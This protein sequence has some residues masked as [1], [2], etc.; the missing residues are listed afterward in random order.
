MS[1]VDTRAYSQW[2][3][4]DI[5]S[6][7]KQGQITIAKAKVTDGKFH[8]CSDKDQELSA[9][10]INQIVIE[11][12]TTKSVCACGR[13]GIDVGTEGYLDLMDGDTR[14]TTLHFDSPYQSNTNTFQA[15]DTSNSYLVN[16]GDWNP[17]NGALG[18]VR[19]KV[20][21]LE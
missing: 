14:I 8:V 1:E 5:E 19:V 20:L 7:F 4:I 17:E 9:S 12:G 10:Q 11:P 13:Y 21:K 3:R 18:N 16:V 15:M 6:L 2:V